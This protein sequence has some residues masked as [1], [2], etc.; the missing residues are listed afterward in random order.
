ML[1]RLVRE[2]RLHLAEIRRLLALLPCWQL[3]NCPYDRQQDCPV[4][5]EPEQPCWVNRATCPG[6]DA[7]DCYFCLVYRS[8]PY[9]DYFRGLLATPAENR[10]A[11]A[12][13][14]AG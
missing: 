1:L 9:A 3:R 13:N 7:R 10:Q 6:A 12:A 2:A 4:I 14:V 8:A 11:V 5:L